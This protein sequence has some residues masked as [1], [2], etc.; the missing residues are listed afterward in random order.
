MKIQIG[1]PQLNNKVSG[2]SENIRKIK[3]HKVRL[4]LGTITLNR[5]ISS[6]SS[7]AAKTCVI[8]DKLFSRKDTKDQLI[9][10]SLTL[11]FNLRLG[12]YSKWSASTSRTISGEVI[13]G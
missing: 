13:R 9:T 12:G 3:G 2:I 1:L 10:L 8:N 4:G 7:G 6:Q 11:W 5:G